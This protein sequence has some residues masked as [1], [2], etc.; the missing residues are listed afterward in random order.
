MKKQLAGLLAA[1]LLLA[2]LAGCGAGK[3][4]GRQEAGSAPAG[5]TGSLAAAEK[6]RASP[7][8]TTYEQMLRNGYA[9]DADGRLNRRDGP[10]AERRY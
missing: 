5:D 7:G 4:S 2:V 9:R 8:G 10:A 1:L 3:D 6:Q